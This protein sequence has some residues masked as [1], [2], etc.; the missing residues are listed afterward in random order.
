MSSLI[1]IDLFAG[2]GGFSLGLKNAGFIVAQA[3][4][5]DPKASAT[6]R[7]NHPEVDFIQEDVRN[8]TPERLMERVGLASGELSLLVAGPPCQGFSESNRRTRSTNN[9]RNS[10]YQEFLRYLAAIK[11]KWFIFE[12]VTGLQTLENGV[13]LNAILTGC[14][15]IGYEVQHRV[16]NS[17]NFGVPQIRRRIF[18]VG[19]RVKKEVIFPKETHNLEAGRCSTVQDAI[20][21]L[22]KLSNGACTDYLQYSNGS[23]LSNYQKIMRKGSK[24]NVL[25]GNLVTKNSSKIIA[26]Y[27]HVRPGENWS[28][29]PHELMDNYKDRSRCHTG[30]YHRLE[31]ERPSKVIGN[32]RKN[33]LIHPEQHRGLSI[34]EAARLQS[35]PDHYVFVGSIGFQQQQVGDA[36]PPLLVEQVAAR[37]K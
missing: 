9:P 16:L 1:A 14:K 24:S 30:I 35:F 11:P 37:I 13:V 8:L 17:A 20:N 32:F 23:K 6:Y 26:R 19:N 22:P 5:N 2:A 29:I 7:H 36:V 33:M 15:K 34:R 28:S 4:E 18:I 27:N 25:Q 21:D 31:W 3:V 10:L 12:N